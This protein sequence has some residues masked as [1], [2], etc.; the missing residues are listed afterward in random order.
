MSN[1]FIKIAFLLL[2]AGSAAQLTAQTLPREFEVAKLKIGDWSLRAKTEIIWS[3]EQGRKFPRIEEINCYGQSEHADFSMNSSAAVDLMLRFRGPDED[4]GL[5]E[6]TAAGDHLWLYIDGERWEYANIERRPSELLNIKY[7]VY[8]R[9]NEIIIP[10]W[11]GFQAVRKSPED[12][13]TNFDLIQGKLL[14]AKKLAWGFK[15]RDWNVVD[16]GLNELPKGWQNARYL[17]DNTHWREA[18]DWCSRQV[19]S[20]EART[21]PA[22]FLKYVEP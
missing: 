10:V 1:K 9:E 7:P 20:E 8:D 11:R 14:S 4:G 3:E 16:R 12:A 5:G 17:I 19:A 15:S 22:D 18:T 6:I 2:V 13:W 21:L